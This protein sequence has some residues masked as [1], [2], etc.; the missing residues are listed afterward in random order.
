MWQNFHW[1]PTSGPSVDCGL[2]DIRL[3]L[4]VVGAAVREP[5]ICQGDPWGPVLSNILAP[6]RRFIR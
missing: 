3:S 5:R 4:W 1:W 2:A 6:D